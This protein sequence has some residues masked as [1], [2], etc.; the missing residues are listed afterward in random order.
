[1]M[2]MTV[3][4]VSVVETDRIDK[5]S[6]RLKLWYPKQKKEKYGEKVFDGLKAKVVVRTTRRN[7]E[8]LGGRGCRL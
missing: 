5:E 2:L 6:K 7:P 4:V 3:N 1:M 8:E